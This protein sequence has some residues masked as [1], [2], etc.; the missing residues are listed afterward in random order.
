MSTTRCY[1][2]N[3]KIDHLWLYRAASTAYFC[4]PNTGVQGTPP[5]RISTRLVLTPEKCL[6]FESTS[7]SLLLASFDCPPWVGEASRS[8]TSDPLYRWEKP[9]GEKKNRTLTYL[10]TKVEWKPCLNSYFINF[11]TIIHRP[12]GLYRSEYKEDVSERI[13]REGQVLG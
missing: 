7:D 3:S 8:D 9:P 10:L 12:F 2:F 6:K 1:F 11:P 4:C 13:F 5:R